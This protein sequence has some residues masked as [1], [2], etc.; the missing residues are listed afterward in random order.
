MNFMRMF[1]VIRTALP[2]IKSVFKAYKETTGPKGN[3]PEGDKSF[4]DKYFS[5][6]LAKNNLAAP[7]LD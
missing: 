1:K 3:N 4:F 2:Y 6:V 7:P 5:T